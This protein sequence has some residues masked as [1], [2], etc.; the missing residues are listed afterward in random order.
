MLL[1][2]VRRRPSAGAPYGGRVSAILQPK[3]QG[4]LVGASGS[5]PGHEGAQE[6]Q[7]HR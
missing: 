3:Q 2:Q 5:D 7:V 1:P 6:L 4:Q